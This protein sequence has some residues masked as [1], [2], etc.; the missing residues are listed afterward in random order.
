MPDLIVSWSDYHEKIE[1][2]AAQIYESGW[3]FNQIICIAKGGLRAGDLLCRLFDCPL[4]I[5]AA[6]SYGGAQNRDRGQIQFSQDLAMTTP[7]LGD[8][9]LLVDDLV[10]SGISL[11][12]SLQW[13][14]NRYN[15]EIADLRTATL[16]YKACSIVAPDYYVDYLPDNPWIRQPFE[17]YESATPEAIAAKYRALSRV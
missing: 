6:S 5:L 15:D 16:W 4:A 9:V 12:A 8:R 7:H 3:E 11:K 10:D 2:L 14:K 13:L 1:R 17:Y